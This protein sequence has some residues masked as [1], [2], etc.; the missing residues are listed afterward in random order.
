MGPVDSEHSVL[1][2]LVGV[3]VTSIGGV[4]PAR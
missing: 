1:R 3:E 4:R 2:G